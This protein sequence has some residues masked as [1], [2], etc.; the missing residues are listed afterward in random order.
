MISI[1]M[2]DMVRDTMFIFAIMSYLCRA[3]IIRSKMLEMKLIK[4]YI[5]A[6]IKTIT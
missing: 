4:K 2:F 5:P 6:A 3:A 1:P